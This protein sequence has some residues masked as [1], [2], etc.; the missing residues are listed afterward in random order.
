MA[1]NLPVVGVTKGMANGF[2]ATVNFDFSSAPHLRDEV[3]AVIKKALGGDPAGF[4]TITV[5]QTG[6]CGLLVI[7]QF[8]AQEAAI[9]VLLTVLAN[10]LGYDMHLESTETHFGSYG[11]TAVIAEAEAA[12]GGRQ[13]ARDPGE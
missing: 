6:T 3:I 8:P 5:D 11:A 12:L 13:L 1:E 9:N 4:D 10:T 7:L 2:T